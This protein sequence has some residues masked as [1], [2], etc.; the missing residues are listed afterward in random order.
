[1][2]VHPAGTLIVPV[3][4]INS[5]SATSSVEWALNATITIKDLWKTISFALLRTYLSHIFLYSTIIKRSSIQVLSWV[6]IQRLSRTVRFFALSLSE[7]YSLYSSMLSSKNTRRYSRKCTKNKCD[8]F[9]DIIW[10]IT[11]KMRLKM[12]NKSQIYDL[13]RSRP[14]HGHRFTKCKMCLSTMMVYM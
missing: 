13:N 14:R 7:N 12:K 3:W 9:N 4:L 11:T 6:K 5:A 1:M 2:A 10:L 8:C